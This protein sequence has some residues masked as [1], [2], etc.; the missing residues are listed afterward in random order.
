MAATVTSNLSFS[1]RSILANTLGLASG[2]ASLEKS[3]NTALA[4]GTG[5]NQADRIYSELA[6]S[7][8]GNYDLDLSGALLDAFGAACVFARVKAIIV[9]ADAANPGNVQVGGIG[10]TAFFGPFSSNADK[11]VVRPGGAVVLFAPDATAWPVTAATADILRFAPS[12]GTC[13]FDFA[14]LGASV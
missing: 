10:A 12:A 1:L 2:Q 9:T 13:L 8:S 3:V 11:V 7:I 6:K 4:S 14:I 5:A